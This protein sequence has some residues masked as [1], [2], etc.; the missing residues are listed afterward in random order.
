MRRITCQSL[1]VFGKNTIYLKQLGRASAPL[2]S[3]NDIHDPRKL[4]LALVISLTNDED[5]RRH[6]LTLIVKGTYKSKLR[7]P[8]ITVN[9]QKQLLSDVLQIGVFKSF[10]IFTQKHLCWSLF[11]IKLQACRPANL[12]KRDSNTGV[13]LWISKNI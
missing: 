1:T 9:L 11:L 12:L 3:L 5:L 10:A 13:F 8:I 2:H 6:Y 7:H 4:K